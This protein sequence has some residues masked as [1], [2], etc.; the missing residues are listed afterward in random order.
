MRVTGRPLLCQRQRE[1][2]RDHTL[3]IY[4]PAQTDVMRI[5]RAA[6]ETG[7]VF[8]ELFQVIHPEWSD[9]QERSRLCPKG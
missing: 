3:I 1:L 8:G 9:H 6:Q 4:I 2:G 7:A 5:F